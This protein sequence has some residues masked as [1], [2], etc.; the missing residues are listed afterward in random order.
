LSGNS[1]TQPVLLI[2]VQFTNKAPSTT[3]AQWAA[4]FF[5]ATNSA[6]HYYSEVSYGQLTLTPAQEN[7]GTSDGVIGWLPLNYAHPDTR[8]SSSDAPRQLAKDA[9]NAANASINFAA[10]DTNH[11]NY[12]AGNELHIIV[13][14]AGYETSYGGAAKACTPNLWGHNWSFYGA[15]PAPTVDGVIVGA[16]GYGGYSEFGEWDCM[17]SSPPGHMATMGIMVHEM[18]HD[19]NWPDLYDTDGGSSGVGYWSIMGSGS[20]NYVSGTFEGAVPAHPDAFLKWYQGWLTPQQ[21]TGSASGVPLQ[22]IE[23]NQR[24]VQLLNNSGGIDWVFQSHSGTGQYFLLENRQKVGYDAGLPGCGVLIWHIDESVTYSNAANAT[25]SRRLVDLEEADGLNGLDGSSRGDAGDP[26]PGTTGNHTFNVSSN[27]NS[28]LYGGADSGVSVTNISSCATTMTVDISAPGSGAATNTP[29]RTPTRTATRTAT[30]TP[31]RT[32]TRTATPGGPTPTRTRTPTR[33]A[34]RIPGSMLYIY[35]P[36]IISN[37]P[38]APPTA[39]PTRTA[40]PGSGGLVTIMT[41]NFEGSFPTGWDLMAGND[42][43]GEYTWG[44]RS[45]RA[46][47]GSY[48][49]WGVGGGADGASLPCGSDYPDAV[50]SFMSYGPFSLAGAT[51]AHM[52]GQLWINSEE[53]WDKFCAYASIDGNNFYG[54][55]ASGNSNGWFNWSLD[56]S[57]VYEIGDLTGEAEVWVALRFY[58]DWY[59]S[60]AE[61]AYVDDIALLKCTGGSCTAAPALT[62]NSLT[63]T[64]D[65]ITLHQ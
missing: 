33:T 55:C 31:T 51:A 26:Y 30:R 45:C 62:S 24:S 42:A 35:L 18:G 64:H 21:I 7:S 60:A 65:A 19:I 29:T 46:F 56:L 41:E 20:W 57:D 37:Y 4:Q 13:I 3:P 39:T 54:L 14:A 58:S 2:L 9:I 5:G 23:D 15:V 44:K 43:A 38:P 12:I 28:R 17:T 22:R 52:S 47:G 50:D 27:P 59:T 34:T 32:A 61:G 49:G 63:I 6:K 36:V 25:T 40:T 1:G 10:Y 16:W 53:D 48:S 11:D 8:D